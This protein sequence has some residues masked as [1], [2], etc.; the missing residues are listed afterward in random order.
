MKTQTTLIIILFIII[1]YNLELDIQN[2][3]FTKNAIT[4]NEIIQLDST[5]KLSKNVQKVEITC[6]SFGYYRE[7]AFRVLLTNSDIIITDYFN[8]DNIVQ[9]KTD[10][11]R[12]KLI[13]FI[14]CFYIDKDQ[15]ILISKKEEPAPITDYPYIGVTYSLTENKK[16]KSQTTL[17]SNINFNPVFL[18]FYKLLN[19]FGNIL[20]QE[21]W[22]RDIW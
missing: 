3:S 2:N 1:L 21:Y 11:T 5:V 12:N 17:Y 19:T 6:T 10:T 18:E 22:K 15:D 8:D 20:N 9:I 14:N 4:N 16:K 7:R 13:E